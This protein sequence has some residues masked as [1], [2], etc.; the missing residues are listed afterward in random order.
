[1]PALRRYTKAEPDD[2]PPSSRPRSFRT[3]LFAGS[4]LL[5][6]G[7]GCCRDGAAKLVHGGFTAVHLTAD[8]GFVSDVDS[9]EVKVQTEYECVW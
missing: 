9:E 4:A 7:G 6:A 5:V 3:L 1:M 2:Q 8:G